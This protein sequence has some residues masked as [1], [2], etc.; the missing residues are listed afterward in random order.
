LLSPNNVWPRE[1]ELSHGQLLSPE[2]VLDNCT[3]LGLTNYSK[4]FLLDTDASQE[5]IGAVLSQEIDERERVI[6]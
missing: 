4:P 6:I 5:G 2:K 3:N 1:A